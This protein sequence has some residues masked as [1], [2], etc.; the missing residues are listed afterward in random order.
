[1]REI[2]DIC[3]HFLPKIGLFGKTAP[4]TV[5]NFA[6]LAQGSVQNRDGFQGTV[7]HRVI[8]KFMIQGK[9]RVI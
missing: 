2:S 7:F 4:K 5:A 8:K 6:K 9:L 1:M 3:V